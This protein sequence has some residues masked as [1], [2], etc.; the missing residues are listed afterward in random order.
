MTTAQIERI[1]RSW[2]ELCHSV[3][4]VLQAGNGDPHRIQLQLNEVAY[5][6]QYWTEAQVY[7][8]DDYVVIINAGLLAMRTSLTSELFIS[9]DPPKHA[10][11]LQPRS[12]VYTGWRGCPPADIN[13]TILGPS[14]GKQW[15]LRAQKRA[16]PNP[17]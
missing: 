9:K 1:N 13:P 16:L 17:H 3:N 15:P 11:L 8:S 10:P 5:W 2:S 4:Q 6:E 14:S 12:K 7:F